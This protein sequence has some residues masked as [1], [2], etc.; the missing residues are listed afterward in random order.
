MIHGFP[1]FAVGGVLLAPFVPQA[2]IALIIFFLLRPLLRRI[3]LDM[4]FANPSL[5]TVCLYIVILASVML[6][7]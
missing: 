6:V 3:P 5:I 4:I 2:T 7:Y 1:E